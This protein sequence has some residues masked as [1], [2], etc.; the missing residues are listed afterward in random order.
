MSAEQVPLAAVVDVYE[1]DQIEKIAAALS[2]AQGEFPAIVKNRT[3]SVRSEKGSYSYNYADLA[4]VLKMVTPVL[5]KHELALIQRTRWDATKLAMCLETRLLHSSG[6]WLGARYPLPS[7]AGR[8]QEMGSALTYARRYSASA[9]LGIATEE[10]DD[11]KGADEQPGPRLAE[12]VVADHL[13][14]IEAA[15][16]QEQLKK[17]YLAAAKAA[18]KDQGALARILKASSARKAALKGNGAGA[19]K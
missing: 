18:E 3:A 6:Q 13:A 11:G 10:D 16:D 19:T 7:G 2:K 4:D 15:A 5:S 14:N 12:S 17:A 9:L 1:S 8:P